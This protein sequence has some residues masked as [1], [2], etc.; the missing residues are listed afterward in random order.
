MH[1]NNLKTSSSIDIIGSKTL[2]SCYLVKLFF[3]KLVF[4]SFLV[5][6]LIVHSI[7]VEAKGLRKADIVEKSLLNSKRLGLIAGLNDDAATKDINISAVDGVSIIASADT[8]RS[9]SKSETKTASVSYGGSVGASIGFQEAENSARSTTYNNSLISAEGGNLNV[10]SGGDTK[11]SGANLEATDTALTVGGDLTVESLQNDSH[12]RSKSKGATVG[13]S[14]GGANVGFNFAKGNSDRTWVDDITSITGSNSVTINTAGNTHIKGAK[15][16]NENAAGEDLGN[17]TLATNSLTFEDIKN[18]DE[19][20]NRGGGF[21]ISGLGGKGDT[22][23]SSQANPTATRNK[24]PK[25]STTISLVNESRW[26]EGNTKATIGDGN[27]TIGGETATAEQ[28]LGLNRDS[29]KTEEITRDIIDGA[30]NAS[31]TID[32]RLLTKTGRDSIK[33]DFKTSGDLIVDIGGGV[34]DLFTEKSTNLTGIGNTN[35]GLLKNIQEKLIKRNIG[36]SLANSADGREAT[37]VLGDESATPAQKQA[38]RNYIAQVARAEG[39]SK[40]TIESISYADSEDVSAGFHTRISDSLAGSTVFINEAKDENQNVGGTTEIL[41]EEL[42][43]A[44]DAQRGV[45]HDGRNGLRE[46]YAKGAGQDF[47]NA[48]TTAFARE[49]ITFAGQRDNSGT[50]YETSFAN[51]TLL[52]A[53]SDFASLIPQ[54]ERENFRV[55]LKN[56]KYFYFQKKPSKGHRTGVTTLEEGFYID[57]APKGL[58]SERQITFIND[59]PNN[60][61]TDQKVNLHHAEAIEDVVKRSNYTINI[62]STTGG[63]HG[64]RSPH[65]EKR[66]TDINIIN[67]LRV[68]NSSTQSLK[69]IRDLQERLIRN[70]QTN[71]VLG[72]VLNVN[73]WY[74]ARP[75]SQDLIDSHD[76]HIHINSPSSRQ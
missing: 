76:D 18:S 25:G 1:K 10:T 65:Y 64:K 69:N 17:L 5:F 49:D 53:N 74:N 57:P 9:N 59:E 8:F 3:A 4:I 21:S 44:I 68:R 23:D 72:P 2:I 37:R 35:T 6:S 42:H 66:A 26:K 61:T 39:L 41:G 27:I 24:A 7:D 56:N 29:N 11:L 52:R 30:L 22:T 55:K 67:G 15:I 38:A 70:P 58:L 13:F 43:H 71:Q 31:V 60:P 48:L 73:K 40:D 33:D 51:D 32:N 75:P 45:N 36:R 46:E 28:L 16:A 47:S 63:K 34:A 20:R 62:N 12:S 19:S 14:S 50:D 54:S